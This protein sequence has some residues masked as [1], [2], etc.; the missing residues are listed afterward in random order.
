MDYEIVGS[1]M[2]SLRISLGNG[3]KIYSDSGKLLSKTETVKMTPRIVGGLIGAIERK[4]TG[5]T[6]MLTEFLS[7]GQDDVVSV[8]GVFPGKIKEIALTDGQEF[9][10]EHYAFL[11]A[12][13]TVKF[14]I[15]TVSLGAAF[16]GG[17]GLILQKFVGPGKVFI[18]TVG[19]TIEHTLDG[20]RQLE[21]DP[22]HIAGFDSSLQYKVRFVDN[23]RTAMFGGVGLFLATFTGTG[24]VIMHSVSRF[25]MSSEIY[26][27]GLAQNPQKH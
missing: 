21:V 16:F 5:A 20:T 26:L 8:A 17:A 2:Q 22:G 1:S 7:T 15:Q 14:T 23:I 4:M 11:A 6:G 12:E 13:D 9:I 3:E 24:R 25:K 27:A 19:D 10:A 18:H